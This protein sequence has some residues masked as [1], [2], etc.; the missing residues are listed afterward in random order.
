MSVDRLIEAVARLKNP[1]VMGL[2][3][4][5]D[6]VPPE[7]MD[8]HIRE[9][10][11]TLESAAAAFLEF[12]LELLELASGIIPAVKPQLACYEALGPSGMAALRETLLRARDMGFYVIADA[13]RGDIGSTAQDYSAAYLGRVKIGSA[14]FEPFPADAMTVNPYLGSDNLN[15]FLEDC[16]R[17]GKMVFVLCKTSNKSSVELQELPA[18]DRQLYRVVAEQCERAG[19]AL[20]GKNGYTSV[21][22]VVGA[23]HPIQLRR[24]RDRFPSIYFLVPGYGA[25]GGSAD[26]VADA[27]D[28]YGRGAI[29]NS[30]R[31]LIGAWQKR[32]DMAWKDAVAA[33]IEDMRGAL[34][35]AVPGGF[36]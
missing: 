32:P 7:I 11:E 21:G 13:K 5:P 14:E 20:P 10:G 12:N 4:R 35:R 33:A 2:D 36:V 25:Q 1:A 31:G 15:Q 29:V 24:L 3:P 17:Y 28:K 6:L 8:R 23:T 30:S 22:M 9:K 16:K 27:F 34:R 18:G 19:D 26:D